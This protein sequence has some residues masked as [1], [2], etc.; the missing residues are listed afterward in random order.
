MPGLVPGIQPTAPAG[1][2]DEM[3]PGDKRRDDSRSADPHP[4][5]RW[6]D[7]VYDLLRRHNVTQFA[8]VPDALADDR[9]G[10][11][12]RGRRPPDPRGTSWCSTTQRARSSTDS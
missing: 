1:A 9:E 7:Q 3:D 2:S 6:Q 10:R 8:Y 12:T 11:G 5:S 4:T